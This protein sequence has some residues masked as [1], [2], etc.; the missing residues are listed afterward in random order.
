[1]D[2]A[3]K[4]R[5][6][7]AVNLHGEPPMIHDIGPPLDL[8]AL[9]GFCKSQ[10]VLRGLVR[11]ILFF[12]TTDTTNR[13]ALEMARAGMPSGI[14]VLAEVQ[15][16]GYGRRGRAWFSSSGG[17][18]FSLFLTPGQP[19][20][21]FP[22]VSL[23][24]ASALVSA[25]EKTTGAV[26]SIKWPNDVLLA[27]KKIAGMLSESAGHGDPYPS[28]VLGV[29]VNVNTADFPP[30]LH[31]TATSISAVCGRPIDRNAL[32]RDFLLF[33]SE[34]YEQIQQRR[35]SPLMQRVRAACSTLNQRVRIDAPGRTF[36]GWAEAIEPDGAL[37]L[38]MGDGC[39]RV[40]HVGDVTTL[41]ETRE[42]APA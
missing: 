40:I 7:D 15:T 26:A 5:F 27:G 33:F 32:L 3:L 1:M 20:Q 8:A 17:L 6:D 34:G 9:E 24:A 12:E 13:V 35:T 28:L 10:P 39:H 29:G 11:E 14:L 36:E 21:T 18:A 42:T 41:R 30:A 25:V 19:V 4:N 37:R 2:A 38:R 16:A 23:A 22:L 31:E